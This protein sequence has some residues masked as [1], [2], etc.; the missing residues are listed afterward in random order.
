MTNMIRNPG[1][2]SLAIL[3]SMLMVS[4]GA[5]GTEHMGHGDI[6][7]SRT[8]FPDA[9]VQPHGKRWSCAWGLALTKPTKIVLGG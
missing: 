7:W 5:W 8:P 4:L 1:V 3:V 2:A 9:P 6:E